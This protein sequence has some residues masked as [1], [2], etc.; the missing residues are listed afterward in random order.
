MSFRFGVYGFGC[1]QGFW[2]I[3][4]PT[5]RVQVVSRTLIPLAG[6]SKFD[7]SES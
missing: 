7:K 1:F 3:I 6:I 4:L 5:F 2:A